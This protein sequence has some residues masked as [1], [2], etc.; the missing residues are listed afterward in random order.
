MSEFLIPL[1]KIKISRSALLYNLK[2]FKKLAPKV[3]FAP[4]LKSN[5]YGHGIIEI[6]KILDNQDISFLIINSLDEVS[7]LRQNGIKSKILIAGYSLPENIIKSKLNDVS[8]TLTD[9]DSIRKLAKSLKKKVLLH[10]KIDTGMSRQ[11][12]TE[13]DFNEAILLIKS[14]KNIILEGLFSHLAESEKPDSSLTKIQINRWGVFSTK[15]KKEFPTIKYFHL[16]NT[17]GAYFAK[18]LDVNIARLGLGLYGISEGQGEFPPRQARGKQKFKRVELKPVLEMTSMLTNIKKIKKGENVG[19]N[20]TFT[21]PKNMTIA[22]VPV[23]YFEGVDRRL[24][25][26]GYFTVNNIPCPIIGKVSMNMTTVDISHLKSAK[27]GDDVVVISQNQKMKNSVEQIAKTV[28]A[29][30]YEI[31]VHIPEHLYR[32]VVI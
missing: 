8:F 27:T 2:E 11:G 3:S 10:L 17:S 22:T 21:T 13:N 25:N 20:G 7:A 32:E 19:Y 23:G 12:I 26:S 15:F 14:N 24:S 6:G 4:V 9:I 5:A 18:D 1:V 16:T 30:P 31:L 28:G 29:I